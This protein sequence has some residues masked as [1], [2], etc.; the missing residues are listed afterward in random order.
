MED[1]S[2]SPSKVERFRR[3]SKTVIR[4]APTIIKQKSTNTWGYTLPLAMPL[5]SKSGLVDLV[6]DPMIPASLIHGLDRFIDDLDEDRLDAEQLGMADTVVTSAQWSVSR[7]QIDHHA[8]QILELARRQQ[9]LDLKVY[10]TD[11]KSVLAKRKV[12]IIVSYTPRHPFSYTSRAK[13]PNTTPI[14]ALVLAVILHSKRDCSA[15]EYQP[16]TLDLAAPSDVIHEGDDNLVLGSTGPGSHSPANQQGDTAS[17]AQKDIRVYASS[18]AQEQTDGITL[19]WE[20]KHFSREMFRPIR[21]EDSS[22]WGDSVAIEAL[23]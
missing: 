13:R 19:Y 15:L 3:L 9:E 5:S 2:I 23:P 10:S 6:F 8:P 20:M 12:S 14:I 1:S 4:N 11:A 17:R 16:L 22:L 7:Q 18:P 21:R